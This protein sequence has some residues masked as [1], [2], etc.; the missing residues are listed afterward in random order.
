MALQLLCAL[1][2]P[3]SSAHTAGMQ[4]RWATT[5][6]EAGHAGAALARMVELSPHGLAVGPRGVVWHRIAASV[7]PNGMHAESLLGGLMGYSFCDGS[8]VFARGGVLLP[9]VARLPKT[10]AKGARPA[11]MDRIVPLLPTTAPAVARTASEALSGNGIVAPWFGL[12][13]DTTDGQPWDA[14]QALVD[15]VFEPALRTARRR[16]G[17]GMDTT[18]LAVSSGVVARVGAAPEPITVQLLK[19][20]TLFDMSVLST[21]LAHATGVVRRTLHHAGHLGWEPHR[22]LGQNLAGPTHMKP[23][24]SMESVPVAA[25]VF[26]AKRPQTLSAHARFAALAWLH[27]AGESAP[28]MAYVP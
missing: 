24:F 21:W 19:P 22:L 20:E 16:Y 2:Q 18:H 9:W 3:D 6:A 12:A 14:V 28:E 8:T 27:A 13:A 25:I 7:S 26:D 23:D 4:W 10:M 15:T 17:A 5:M 11:L 1:A